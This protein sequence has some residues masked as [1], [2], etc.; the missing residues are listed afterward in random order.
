[1]RSSGQ[2]N[3]EAPGQVSSPTAKCMPRPKKRSLE[4]VMNDQETYMIVGA[5]ASCLCTSAASQMHGCTQL[6]P[7]RCLGER[8]ISQSTR[9]SCKS[10]RTPAWTRRSASET[11]PRN[12]QE[13][14]DGE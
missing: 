13:G 10:W 14:E 2:E 1:M 7:L 11:L 4:E 5:S 3:K 8:S 12:F 6:L 9:T